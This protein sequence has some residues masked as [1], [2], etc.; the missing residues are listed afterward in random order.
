MYV[1]TSNNEYRKLPNY[2]ICFRVLIVP[3]FIFDPQFIPLQDP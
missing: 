3:P 2:Q 1:V